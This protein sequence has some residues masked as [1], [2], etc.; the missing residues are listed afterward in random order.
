MARICPSC[1]TENPDEARFCFNCATPLTAGAPARLER[2]NAA[3]LSA[4]LVGYTSLTEREDPE[5]V[6]SVVTRAFAR[7]TEEIGRHGGFVDKFIGD[8]IL[9]LFGVP[10]AHEDDAK[11][12]VHAAL[13]MQHALATFNDE[14]AAEGRG[15]LAM[16]I[17][18]EAGEVLVA[19]DADL[20]G[21]RQSGTLTGDAVNTTAR[22]A[23]AGS[24]GAV[25]VGPNVHYATNTAFDY[26]EL[27]PLSLKGKAEPVPAW[28]VLGAKVVDAGP[29][30][31]LQARLI[32]RDAEIELL[33][34]TVRRVQTEKTPSLVTILGAPG[35]GKSRLGLELERYID[36]LEHPLMCLRGRCLSYGNA[37]YS[38]FAEAIKAHFGIHDDDAPDVM[39][40]KVERTV[41][42]LFGT[43]DLAAHVEVLVGSSRDHAFKREEL[44]AGWR[45]LVESIAGRTP[46]ALFFEDIHW[47]DDGLL[48]FIDHLA[49]WANGSILLVTLAR[50]ELLDRRP[51]WGE[52]KNNYI[53]VTLGPLAPGEI[54]T[55]LG[56]LV[57]A[58]LPD[59][60]TQMI[61]DRS[62]GNPLFGEEIVRMLIDRGHLRSTEHG[63][64]VAAPTDAVDVPRSIHSLIA[65]RID[66]LSSDEKSVL[67]DASVVGRIFWD[68]AV[69]RIGQ[70][71]RDDSEAQLHA[72]RMKEF[73]FRREPSVFSGERQYAFHHVLIR[74]VAYDSLPKSSRAAKH[75][76]VASW[77]QE[78][79]AERSE[80]IAELLA[81]HYT[82]ALSYL[83]ELGP[84]DGNRAQVEKD[85]FRWAKA[86]GERTFGLWQQREAAR[87]LRTAVN[88]AANV[89]TSDGD[90][91]ALLE[92][93]ARVGEG[94][95]PYADVEDALQAARIL[96]QRL[97][98]EIDIGRVEARLAHVAYQSGNED[99][100]IRSA[101]SALLH[102]EPFGDSPELAQALSLLA[103]YYRRRAAWDDAEHYA[104]RAQAMADRV[105][106]RFTQGLAMMKLGSA[107]LAREGE[108]AIPILEE[109][110]RFARE[111]GD[112]PL[113][114]RGLIELVEG[115]E[116]A[117]GNY[118][119]LEEMLREGLDLASKAGSTGDAAWM[120]ELVADLR[121]D[122]GIIDEEVERL[123]R[124][125]IEKGRALG[126]LAL[127]GY[128][129]GSLAYVKTLRGD[130]AAAERVLP[131][132]AAIID[133]SLDSYMQANEALVR[134]LI[135]QARGQLDDACA[136]LADA[137]DSIGDRIQGWRG[138]DLLLECIRCH[139]KA[140]RPAVAL[141]A[142]ERLKA[143][144]RKSSPARAFAT[145]A[146]GLLEADPERSRALLADAAAQFESLER[147]IDLARCLID[148]AETE[149]RIGDDPGPKL[150]QAREIL[151]S[152]GALLFVREI[153]DVAGS[154]PS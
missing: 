73:V 89:G 32:G 51:R 151:K 66:S 91:A 30:S 85:A 57:E 124:D 143:L 80:D 105:G 119:Q 64:Q 39:A 121:V 20:T 29:R 103:S 142:E 110:V 7:L 65:S 102:L 144:S 19:A 26:V 125:A 101:E 46:L 6:R 55:L 76:D 2:K 146:R 47:A 135:A 136:I 108:A 62:E 141:A 95:E 117:S 68:S 109:A 9:A 13:G 82:Q 49:D 28:E 22:L 36:D 50:R 94:V 11:R 61:V 18:I 86:A 120:Q 45:S 96:Y 5:V 149:R 72:L 3:V 52:G 70:R 115:Y 53:G 114:L 133:Q 63:W 100:V 54:E 14:L 48:D 90:R 123:Y 122:R 93:Y 8:E 99:A 23:K 40:D 84:G 153:D 138:Q 88:L 132:I 127:I 154:D 145:C 113:L 71:S 116:H 74:D 16:R 78:Q 56:D 118:V 139:V 107:I 41:D 104:R 130:L 112:L 10:A 12:A 131:E 24:P 148:L 98:A 69:S 147:R 75:I 60:L 150:H 87:W 58:R 25:T 92:R 35:V 111:V 140:G 126:E 152:A 59:D 83:E 37:S 27:E 15:R 21:G 33:R 4:D 106:D 77:A 97:D 79:A 43:N 137:T 44:F 129:L 1:A 34:E 38:A 31:R 81:T 134:S 67:Q 42:D 17:G 128:G